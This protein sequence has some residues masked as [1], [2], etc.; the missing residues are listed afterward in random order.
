MTEN[1]YRARS[2]ALLLIY[3]TMAPSIVSGSGMGEWEARFGTATCSDWLS[4]AGVSAR[5]ASEQMR[6]EHGPDV[7]IAVTYAR[8]LLFRVRSGSWDSLVL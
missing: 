8:K 6:T 3:F 5:L 4:D 1:T 2:Y 7:S